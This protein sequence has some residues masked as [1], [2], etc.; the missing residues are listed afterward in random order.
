MERLMLSGRV[1]TGL[2]RG[3]SF[4]QIDWVRDQFITKLGIDPYPGTL[5]LMVDSPA[6]LAMWAEVKAG[7]GYFIIPPTSEWCNARC[8]SV[9]IAG[10]LPGAIILPEVPNYPNAQVEVIA[11][12]PLRKQLSLVDSDHLS[13]E[14]AQPIPVGTVIFDVDGTLVDSV[15]AYRVVAE[16]AT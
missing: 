5:N 15:E 14:I 12:L 1:V 16:R 10:K 2:D 6:D 9:R 7:S 11:A 8:Y 3:A 4:T 13:L